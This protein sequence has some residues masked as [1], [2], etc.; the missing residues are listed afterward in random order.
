MFLNLL[1]HGAG[2]PS[3]EGGARAADR[4]AGLLPARAR[5]EL[6]TGAEVVEITARRGRVSGVRLADGEPS[7]AVVIA[8][9]MPGALASLA[10]SA[11]PERYA[12]AL[13][14]YRPG[15][16]TLKLDWALDGP[17]PWS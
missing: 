5:R 13:R 2:W 11:L 9:V 6:R 8:D 10:G 4:C 17:I 14:R 12:A 7:P 15:P 16:A 1:G 3:P